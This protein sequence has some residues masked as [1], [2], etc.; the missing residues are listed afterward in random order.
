MASHTAESHKEPLLGTDDGTSD[1]ATGSDPRVTSG[2]ASAD[3]SSVYASSILVLTLVQLVDAIEYGIV[4]PALYKYIE[5][6]QGHASTALYG[7]VLASFSL[8]SLLSKAP[9]GR[10]CDERGFREVYAASISVA[11]LGNVLFAVAGHAESV[12][13]IFIGR[14]LSGVGCANTSLVYAYVARTLPKDQITPTMMKV[15][16]SFPIG[17]VLGPATNL[18]TSTCDF[19]IGGSGRR[20]FHVESTNA[21]GLLMAIVLAALLSAI[22]AVLKEPPPYTSTTST[23]ASTQRCHVF[24]D[25]WSEVRRPTVAMHFV[26]IFVFNFFINGSE[27]VVVP[28]TQHAFGFTPLQNS[29]VYAGVAALILVLTVAT[30]RLAKAVQDK[31]LVLGATILYA[32]GATAVCFLWTFDMPLWKFLLGELLLVWNIPFVFAPN[33]ALFS[34][35]V[36]RS[37]NQALLS[38]S[39]SIM[40][41]VGSIAGPL[42]LSATGVGSSSNATGAVARTMFMGNAAIAALTAVLILCVWFSGGALEANVRNVDLESE[43]ESEKKDATRS[44]QQRQQQH[45]VI[46]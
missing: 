24:R 13:L 34:K 21:P 46:K 3:A 1:P 35:Q 20:G 27:A 38:S 26:V 10:W 29:Y 40:A 18:L 16:L 42:W 37:K 11:I 19:K 39:L 8:T 31:V 43:P 6:V 33:R 41:S 30:I 36:A 25:W 14:M 45:Q 32:I 2:S 17:L 44:A 7:L 12:A 23:S 15:G 5:E 28:V 9:L 4:M 22:L